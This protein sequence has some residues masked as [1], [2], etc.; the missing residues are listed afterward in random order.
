[1]HTRASEEREQGG[2]AKAILGG[3]VKTLKQHIGQ[4]QLVSEFY[5]SRRAENVLKNHHI[6]T[7]RELSEWEGELRDFWCL[8]RHESGVSTM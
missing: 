1:M 4:Q 5:M 6:R 3:L 2:T 8:S 7:I